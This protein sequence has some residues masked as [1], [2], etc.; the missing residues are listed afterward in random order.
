M[1]DSIVQYIT[2][3]DFPV[4]PPPPHGQAGLR[5]S[6]RKVLY[7]LCNSLGSIILVYESSRRVIRKANVSTHADIRLMNPVEYLNSMTTEMG[8][9]LLIGPNSTIVLMYC[10]RQA[11]KLRSHCKKLLLLGSGTCIVFADFRAGTEESQLEHAQRCSCGHMCHS[12]P[13]TFTLSPG[14]RITINSGQFY[15]SASSDKHIIYMTKR[16]FLSQITYHSDGGADLINAFVNL[17]PDT[18]EPMIS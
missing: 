11:E 8:T 12:N 15:V 18:P 10:H 5:Q 14:D 4:P 9:T 6:S 3:T 13:P 1:V 7:A 17:L 16:E 2:S